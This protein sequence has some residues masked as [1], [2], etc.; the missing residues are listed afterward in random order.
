MN[1]LFVASEG[2]P[3]V[4]TGGLADVIGS[5]PAE[6]RK[7]GV[8]A[9]VILPRYGAIDPGL[10]AKI[11]LRKRFTVALGWRYQ[12]CGILETEQDGVPYYFIDN[13]Y[14]FKR[15][16]LYGYGD[17]AE[18]FAFFS[19][20]VLESL[21][22]LGFNPQVVH[23]HDWQTGMVSVFL[24]T[25][26][27][28]DR[29][30]RDIKSVFTIHNLHYKGAYP[31]DFLEELLEL[32]SEHFT[33]EGM[34]FFGQGSYLKGGLVF[35]DFLTTVSPTY[36]E[37][38]K[39]PYY[40]EKL[41]G[42][43]QKRSD[44]LKGIV[45]GIDYGCYDPR[46]DPSLFA[47]YDRSF[48]EKMKNKAGLQELLGL[49]HE[50]RVPVLSFVGRLV[51]QK[52]LDL[53]ARVLDELLEMDLQLVILGT[54]E[55]KYERFLEQMARRYPEKLSVNLRFDE[56]LA[57]KIYAGS[58]LLLMP[59]LFEPCGISQMIAMRYGTIPLVRETGGLKDT[60]EPFNEFTGAGSGFS[61]KNFNAHD[62]LY[63]V[64]RA[65][66]FYH[67]GKTWSIIVKNAWEQDFSW[68]PSALEYKDLY[69][70]LLQESD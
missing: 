56:S 41:E 22:C 37:E 65:V 47:N 46:T 50:K 29:F 8:D 54:G 2:A 52:G 6:L 64:Q 18:R 25:H 48:R 40:G 42:L 55:K 34:E 30:Y 14:Y 10:A 23:A 49:P 16:M 31:L 60:V 5:L 45:N 67:D 38:I 66:D 7:Q 24:K 44:R 53:V 3:F 36:A 11:V 21:P 4:K 26:Y 61:F 27:S 69:Q 70:G 43:L 58:D 12:Y 39:T 59:S 68:K 9:R 35:S 19:R 1:V 57:R 51:E 28:T 17:D 33:M 13:E 63:T 20:A 32:G 62:M 15:D